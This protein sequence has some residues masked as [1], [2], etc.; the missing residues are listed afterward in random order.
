MRNYNKKYIIYWIVSIIIVIV[1]SIF[2]FTRPTNISKLNK[3][4][5]KQEQIVVEMYNKKE[6]TTNEW[7][8]ANLELDKLY[9][10]KREFM[11]TSRLDFN[12][13]KSHNI[14]EEKRIEPLI[15]NIPDI[16]K[17]DDVLMDKICEYW[18]IHWNISPLCEDWELYLKLKWISDAVWV[19]FWLLV[20]ITYSESHIWANFVGEK[21]WDYNNWS[22]I[23]W[24]KYSNWKTD[25]PKLPDSNWCW[26][27]KFNKI[28]DYWESFAYTIK[29]WYIDKDCKTPEC[30]SQYYVWSDWKVKD[31]RSKRVNIFRN[32]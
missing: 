32:N 4:I 17:S 28:D 13:S 5:D 1:V 21:C 24:R 27:Y 14:A 11:G 31:K 20:G 9:Q 3:D 25:K 15:Y 22:W 23:K 30:I 26:L 19:E 8:K 10:E 18:K 7:R 12:E 6:I 29:Q 2:L 16:A